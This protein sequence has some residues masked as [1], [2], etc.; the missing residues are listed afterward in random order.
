[1]HHYTLIRKLTLIADTVCGPFSM[2]DPTLFRGSVRF[3]LDPFNQHTDSELWAALASAHL[4]EHISNMPDTTSNSSGSGDRS[5]GS[6]D[7]NQRGSGEQRGHT[8]IDGTTRSASPSPSA[9]AGNS[10]GAYRGPL[11]H[12]QV[13]EKG[14][15]FSLGQRQLLCMARAILR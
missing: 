8:N 9:V 14:A 12:K 15:N 1:M 11:A 4:A 7:D 2:Q 5:D 6:G 10:N 3:N 13:A